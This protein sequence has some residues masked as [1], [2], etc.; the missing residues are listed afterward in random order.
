[1]SFSVERPKIVK[2]GAA[3]ELRTPQNGVFAHVPCYY[4]LA[5]WLRKVLSD[6]GRHVSGH[7]V[8]KCNNKSTLALLH[9][10]D[11]QSSRIKHIDNRHHQWREDMERGLVAYECCPFACFTQLQSVCVTQPCPDSAQN[12]QG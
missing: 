10:T 2:E 11:M 8:I 12:T 6:L 1:M 3:R 5:M 7:V 9:N 4:P